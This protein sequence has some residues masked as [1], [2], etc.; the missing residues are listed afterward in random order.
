MAQ[1]VRYPLI[2]TPTIL[3]YHAHPLCES[4]ETFVVEE[5]GAERG[6]PS[7]LVQQNLD[8]GVLRESH[9]VSACDP[10]VVN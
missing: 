8:P 1:H 6:N 10:A 7:P 3:L 5:A 2:E 9:F 4:N